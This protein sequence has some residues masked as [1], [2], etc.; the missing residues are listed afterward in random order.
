VFS[1][2][3]GGDDEGGSGLLESAIMKE[4]GQFASA[5]L[6]KLGK[7]PQ[8]DD[9]DL[10]VA[11]VD[12]VERAERA[13]PGVRVDSLRF[14]RHL[15]ARLSPDVDPRAELAALHASDLYLACACEADDDGA[16]EAV[17]DAFFGDCDAA[18][19]RMDPS[20]GFADEV[21]QR[22]RAKLFVHAPERPARIGEYAGRG[23]LRTFLRVVIMREALSLRRTER[24]SAPVSGEG[25]AGEPWETKDPELLHLRRVYA[26]E[27]AH[28][29]REAVGA[30]TSE[31]RNLVRYHYVDR[32]NIDHIGA[33]Y[34]IHRVSA[35]R[36]LTRIRALLVDSTRAKLAERLRLG[37]SELRSVLRLIESQVDISLRR[38]LGEAPLDS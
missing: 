34:G 3:H 31:E 36:R 6:A 9:D 27:F 1:S 2:G 21:K 24:R 15:A 5:L 4:R 20:P 33:I 37:E 26:D 17:D 35:A 8:R 16:L 14:V 29:F 10:Q 13:W 32:L 22:A 7:V 12:L 11:L 19:A 25:A 18:L 23:E 30:L 38:V 28:A